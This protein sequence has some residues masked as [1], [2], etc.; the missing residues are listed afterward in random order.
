M[1]AKRISEKHKRLR[2]QKNVD[3]FADVQETLTNKNAHIA[4]KNISQK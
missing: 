3:L 2:K 1:A 4:A